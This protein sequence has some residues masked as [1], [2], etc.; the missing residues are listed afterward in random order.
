[1]RQYTGWYVLGFALFG[2]GG[3][4]PEEELAATQTEALACR[5]HGHDHD[6]DHDR[7]RPCWLKRD[8]AFALP[9]AACESS[10]LVGS[11]V[12]EGALENDAPYAALLG[13]EFSYVTP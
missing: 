5:G 1:M 2:C 11:A 3:R 13:H 6:G 4:A 7:P 10:L 8:P 9:I 12:S